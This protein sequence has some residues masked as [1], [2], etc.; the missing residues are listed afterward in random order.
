MSTDVEHSLS[1]FTCVEHSPPVATNTTDS[2]TLPSTTISNVEQT[3]L[4]EQVLNSYNT[5][6]VDYKDSFRRSTLKRIFDNP[7]KLQLL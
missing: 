1:P 4:Q 5:T 3:P 2:L 6:P 7:F